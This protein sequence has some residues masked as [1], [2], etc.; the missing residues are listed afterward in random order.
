MMIQEEL[1]DNESGVIVVEV[2]SGGDFDT[3]YLVQFDDQYRWFDEA[4]LT[5]FIK[6]LQ[7]MKKIKKHNEQKV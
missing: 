5:E 3:P 1:Y 6:K 4:G 7:W 2:L